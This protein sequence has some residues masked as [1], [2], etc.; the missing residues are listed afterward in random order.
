MLSAMRP[1]A[2]IVVFTP[3]T[4]T[5]QRL[6]LAWGVLPQRFEVGKS[7]EELLYN[8]EMALLERGLAKKGENV[9][10]VAG[11]T[12]IQ[13]ATNLMTIRKIGT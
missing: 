1:A 10:L 2:D 6:A 3:H 4:S 8:G 9:V 5:Y 7:T 12:T 13:G 11:S